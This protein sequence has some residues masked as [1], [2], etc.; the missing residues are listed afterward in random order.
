[1]FWDS[2]KSKDLKDSCIFKLQYVLLKH[3]SSGNIISTGQFSNII[4]IGKCKDIKQD[5]EITFN[6]TELSIKPSVFNDFES[7]L[8]KKTNNLIALVKGIIY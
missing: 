1:M 6:V 4:Y 3:S 7:I 2:E 8:N 5:K